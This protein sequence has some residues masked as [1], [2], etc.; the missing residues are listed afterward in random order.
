MIEVHTLAAMRNEM[1]KQAFVGKAL[2]AAARFG[3]R[4]VH[5]LTG[6]NPKAYTA[7]FRGEEL[8][9]RQAIQKAGLDSLPGMAKNLVMKPKST[10]QAAWKHGWKDQGAM[11]KASLVAF[12]AATTAL[13]L[14]D[15]NDNRSV[16][17]K[18]LSGV[19]EGAALL[20]TGGLSLAPA[21]VGHAATMSAANAAGGLLPG[22]K[23][24]NVPT[25]SPTRFVAQ[26]GLRELSPRS[27]KALGTQ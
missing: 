16:G 12:P 17:Q 9:Q 27:P 8:I 18:V 22:A 26:R 3:K 14:R 7:G 10:L 21:L 2:G 25:Q 19:G 24:P 6:I 20:A 5:G 11:G 15:K 4:Q 23:K 13:A 1:E